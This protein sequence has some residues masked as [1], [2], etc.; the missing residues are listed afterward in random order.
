MLTAQAVR[1]GEKGAPEAEARWQNRAEVAGDFA[2][3]AAQAAPNEGRTHRWKA[4]RIEEALAVDAARGEAVLARPPPKDGDRATRDVRGI[5]RYRILSSDKGRSANGTLTEGPLETPARA[6]NMARTGRG[7]REATTVGSAPDSRS[8][9]EQGSRSVGNFP[10][11]ATRRQCAWRL[12]GS[13]TDFGPRGGMRG[14]R[15]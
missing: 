15:R 4:S 5:V 3:V 7:D 12:E 1:K 2:L 6:G 8:A 13:P 11:L 10:K 14:S 9:N